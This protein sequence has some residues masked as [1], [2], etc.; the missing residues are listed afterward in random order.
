MQTEYSSMLLTEISTMGGELCSP[1]GFP[2]ALN[3]GLSV[4]N[5]HLQTIP[6]HSQTQIRWL[7]DVESLLLFVS[8]PS[9]LA[10]LPNSVSIFRALL[11]VLLI[12]SATASQLVKKC[13][14]F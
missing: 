14:E 1:H 10:V 9:A 11:S 2:S 13:A 3:S 4:L 8:Q 7:Q 12:R 5:L 6:Q